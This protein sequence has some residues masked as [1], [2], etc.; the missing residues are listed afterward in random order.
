MKKSRLGK[1]TLLVLLGSLALPDLRTFGQGSTF[2]YQGRLTVN[3]DPA[4]GLFDLRF[5]LF[6]SAQAGSQVGGPLTLAPTGVTNGLFQVDLTFGAASFDG[7][8]R[9]LEISARATGSTNAFTT[10]TPRHAV[11]ATPYAVRAAFFSGTLNATN[12]TGTISDASLSAN[13]PLLT[14][15]A[16]F[17][18][19]VVASNFVGN[20]SGL[21]NLAATNL[22]GQVAD[23][24]LSANIPRLNAPNNLFQ[25]AI[26]AASFSGH[27]GGLTNVPG[28]I[29]EVIPTGNNIQAVA[30]TGYL[31]TNDTVPVVVTL[32][33]TSNI[34]VG[35]TVR[36]SASGAGGW[37]IAQHANQTILIA[38]LPTSFHTSWT[39]NDSPRAWKA[40]TASADGSKMAAVVNGGQIYTSGNFG[41]TWTPR[42]MTANWSAIATSASGT[43]LAATV[44]GSGYVYT[45]TDSGLN[46]SQRNSSGL[47]NW[48][49]I[50]SS[51][52]GSR[53]V[54]C[55]AGSPNGGLAVSI[56]S[57]ATWTFLNNAISWS[58]VGSSADGMNLIAVAQGVGIYVSNNGG[59]TWTNRAGAKSWT[60]ATVSADGSVMA[61]GSFSGDIQVSTDF[62]RN[63]LPGAPTL[64]W[65]GVACSADGARLVA[66]ANGGG[67]FLSNDSGTTWLP[68]NNLGTGLAYTGAAVSA[69]GA[70]LAAVA[71]AGQIYVASKT[72]TTPGTAGALVGARL[73]AVEL[74]HLGNGVFM[75]ISFAGNIRAR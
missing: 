60:C 25:G 33:V 73:A 41:T 19:S 49:G 15:T 42:A 2:T 31:A 75:P 57:G 3:G 32:P 37:T 10:L 22:I 69:D 39:T 6:N 48:T 9:W 27:G 72:S 61:A 16:V 50:A 35:E 64:N 7:G 26:T 12:L 5:A 28:R 17:L 21:T 36:V 34:R 67:V 51:L 53:L 23:A 40:I 29:F 63:W 1:I 30:N 56:N 20:G 4:T 45:S 55:A 43:Q 70:T 62:G 74:Q 44:A 71:S 54:A 58:G 24:Q 46:W 18:R 66:V 52:D 65:A 68:R 59:V 47:R 38:N 11:N 14:N 8:A 13:V